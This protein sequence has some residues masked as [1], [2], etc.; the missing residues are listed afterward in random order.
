M[1]DHAKLV[2]RRKWAAKF[3]KSEPPVGLETAHFVIL[4]VRSEKPPE[5]PSNQGEGF[6]TCYN[7]FQ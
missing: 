1:W 4:P 7:V 5:F 6:C 3:L 2:P